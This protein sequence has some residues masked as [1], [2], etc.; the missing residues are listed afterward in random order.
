MPVGSM[1]FCTW[2]ELRKEASRLHGR[3]GDYSA[4]HSPPE[5]V[6]AS[7]ASCARFSHACCSVMKPPF[8]RSGRGR[9]N[10][11]HWTE[12]RTRDV[13]IEAWP[14]LTELAITCTDPRRPFLEDMSTVCG[15]CEREARD[16]AV[17]A[18]GALASERGNTWDLSMAARRRSSPAGEASW[19][20]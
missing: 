10:S 3:E 2:P 1:H 9:R 6:P 14:G 11:H 4:H 16:E 7:L 17:S 12:I 15:T 20:M 8:C 19:C 5:V 13:N 18:R